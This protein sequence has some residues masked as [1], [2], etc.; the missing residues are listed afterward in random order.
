M[1]LS[2]KSYTIIPIFFW[3][4]IKAILEWPKIEYKAVVNF[5]CVVLIL[6]I[7]FPDGYHGTTIEHLKHFHSILNFQKLVSS[8]KNHVILKYTICYPQKVLNVTFIKKN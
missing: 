3:S 8:H 1:A 5:V 7:N 2:P 4:H 6:E